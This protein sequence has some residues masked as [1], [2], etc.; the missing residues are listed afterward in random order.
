M[1]FSQRFFKYKTSE[2]EQIAK[3]AGLSLPYLMKHIYVSGRDPRFH[4]HNAVALDKASDGELKFWQSTEGT[5]DWEYVMARL[6]YAKIK[7]E[8]PTPDAKKDLESNT[9]A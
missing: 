1:D 4:F 3:S 8:L 7:G 9:Q 2:R 6:A 5:V